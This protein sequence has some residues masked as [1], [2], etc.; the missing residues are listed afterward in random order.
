MQDWISISQGSMLPEP[1]WDQRLA[2]E[3]RTLPDNR[4]PDRNFYFESVQLGA[5]Y[6]AA[7]P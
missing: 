1:E 2:L 5:D 7:R 6:A 4:R 3:R